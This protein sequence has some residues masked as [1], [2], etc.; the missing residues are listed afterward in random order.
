MATHRLLARANAARLFFALAAPLT[1]LA[2]QEFNY[3][4]SVDLG[5][6]GNGEILSYTADQNTL[7]STTSGVGVRIF[8]FTGA[9]VTDRA[10][11]NFGSLGSF[12]DVSSVA[13][14]PFGRGFGVA[15]LV[16]TA[17]GT[18]AGKIAF[19]DYRSGSILGT[20]DVGYHPDAVTF[21]AD[22]LK[23]FITNEGERTSGG[24]TD[25]PGSVSIVDLAGVTG[26]SGI[27]G[28]GG[29][30]VKTFTFESANLAAGVSIGGL[31]YND[32]FSAGNAFR[33]VEPEYTTQIGGKLY[34]TLQE[35]NGIAEF[36]LATEKFTAVRNLGQ[37]TITIDA[38]DRDGPGGTG[39]AQV[40]DTVKAL[41]MPDTIGG[42]TV[43]ANHYVVTANEGDFRG[44]DADRSRVSE[45]NTAGKLDVAALTAQYGAGFLNNAAL[46]RLRVSNLDGDTNGDGLIDQLVTA[47]SRG[48]SILNADTGAL[49]FDSGSLEALLL[50]I[51]PAHHNFDAESPG[52][53]TFDARSTTKGPEPEALK[54]FT[55]AN[56]NTYLALGM[57]RQYGLL[58]YD[59]T[60]PNAPS[61][62]DYVNTFGLDASN[63]L[64][65]TESLVFIPA[66]MSPTG[67][68]YLVAGFEYSGDL[69][70]FAI[71]EPS[72]YALF[73]GLGALGAAFVVRR[74]RRRAASRE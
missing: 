44:D 70:I 10:T 4:G 20:L 58:L 59:I 65:G 63:A 6:I 13:A 18:T 1:P 25:A 52:A 11:V 55:L 50:S 42:Y 9:G 43:G 68:D 19:F 30:N 8:N 62:V 29:S 54:L 71:P 38:S 47:G 7:L 34:V 61:L 37:R 53:L 21:S 24:N 27:G 72:T 12:A 35:N 56:G 31:R 74:R 14:D 40:N 57:E 73:A 69:A 64:A 49:V 15:S 5:G 45:L 17:N 41:P 16:P 67:M 2:A 46:G 32:T 3:V 36:D 60:D 33:H 39:A 66:S 51:D 22:G 23:L 26:T 48:F 28:L